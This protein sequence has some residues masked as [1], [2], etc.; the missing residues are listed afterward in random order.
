MDHFRS[1]NDAGSEISYFGDNDLSLLQFRLG[2]SDNRNRSGR[3]RDS[4][5]N[6]NNI[7]LKT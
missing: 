3:L 5:K 4:K 6:E 7:L 2:S 1:V